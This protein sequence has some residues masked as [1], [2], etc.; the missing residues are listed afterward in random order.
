MKFKEKFEDL[1]FTFLNAC[2]EK[3]K[4][5]A[6]E[7]IISIVDSTISTALPILVDQYKLDYIRN[8]LCLDI[9]DIKQESLVILMSSMNTYKPNKKISLYKYF[10][11]NIRRRVQQLYFKSKR[12]KRAPSKNF[13]EL[14]DSLSDGENQVPIEIFLS[15][16]IDKFEDQYDVMIREIEN[17]DVKEIIIGLAKDNEKDIMN[18]FF[19][20]NT[21]IET[22]EKLNISVSETT[23]VVKN[24]KK[25]ARIALEMEFSK[26]F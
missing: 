15:S 4:N 14:T 13:S 9:P 21:S 17:S 8:V 11:F 3:T 20:G 24:V 2:D 6:R 26:L 5:K 18:S 16:R 7:E 10:S 22:S 25:R 23:K 12:K 1:T 19:S